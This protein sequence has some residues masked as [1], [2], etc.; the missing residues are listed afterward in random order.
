MFEM[1]DKG[2]TTMTHTLTAKEKELL[3]AIVESEY[4]SNVD[5]GV[6]DYDIW[7]DYVVNTKSKGGV[8]ASLQS[9][10]FVNATIV[11]KAKSLMRCNG[12]SDST[13]S[14]TAEGFAA[15]KASA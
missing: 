11:P 13:L 2:D 12:I 14:I 4:Q 9:K 6:I 8:F 5:E 10:G 15:L 3:T 1:R 7:F